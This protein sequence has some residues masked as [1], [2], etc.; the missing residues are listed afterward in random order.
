MGLQNRTHK[1]KERLQQQQLRD[2][3]KLLADYKKSRTDL[4]VRPKQAV[5][6]HCT[7]KEH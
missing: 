3:V 5:L 6:G 1:T 4:Q 2:K 7:D